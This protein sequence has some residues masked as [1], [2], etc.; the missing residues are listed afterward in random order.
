MGSQC[1]LFGVAL[2]REPGPMGRSLRQVGLHFMKK[3]PPAVKAV[4]VPSLRN[5]LRHH[6][7]NILPF[8]QQLSKTISSEMWLFSSNSSYF[9]QPPSNY[10]SFFLHLQPLSPLKSLSVLSF[11]ENSLTLYFHLILTLPVPCFMAKLIEK[12]ACTLFPLPSFTAL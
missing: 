2:K 1:L 6:P 8:H 12:M 4:M 7:L 9:L 11:K 3:T 10:Y 5:H